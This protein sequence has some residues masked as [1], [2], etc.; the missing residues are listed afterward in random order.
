LTNDQNLTFLPEFFS[1]D[2]LSSPGETS[3]NV[4]WMSGSLTG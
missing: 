3:S 2:G 1:P 4:P